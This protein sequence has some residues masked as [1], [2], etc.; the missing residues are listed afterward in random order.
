[1]TSILSQQKWVF[2]AANSNA[3]ISESKNIFLTFFCISEIYI[4]FPT[5]WTKYMSLRSYLFQ[6]L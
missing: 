3:I 4:K 2:N 1:M 5:L 6:K